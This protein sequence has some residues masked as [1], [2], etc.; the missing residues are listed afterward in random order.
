[1]ESIININTIEV[2]DRTKELQHFFTEGK[3]LLI[4]ER[5]DQGALTVLL[6]VV[7][8]TNRIV[9]LKAV[10]EEFPA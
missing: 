5:D 6:E 7:I 3:T 2:T 9:E 8:G 10:I 4:G 1:M